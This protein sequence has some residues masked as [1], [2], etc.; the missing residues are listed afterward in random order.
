[1]VVRFSN[2][3]YGIITNRSA[4]LR[5]IRHADKGLSPISA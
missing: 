4:N 5:S 2:F 1:M 3:A